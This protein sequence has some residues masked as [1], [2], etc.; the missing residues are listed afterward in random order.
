MKKFLIVSSL[1]AMLCST[2][3]SAELGYGME[4]FMSRDSQKERVFVTFKEP[5]FLSSDNFLK[6][7]KEKA[8]I[9]QKD[10]IQKYSGRQNNINSLWSANA[11]VLDADRE[12]VREISL[13]KDVDRIFVNPEMKFFDENSFESVDNSNGS[14]YALKSMNVLRAWEDFG[15][16]GAD[17]VAGVVDSGLNKELPVFKGKVIDAKNFAGDIDDVT[18][19]SGH[20]THVSG[21]V[22]GGEVSG[23]LYDLVWG[24]WWQKAGTFE[25]NIGVA[26]E[27]EIL[28]SKCAQDDGNITFEDILEGLEW[29]ADPDGNPDTRDGARVINA[30]LGAD[31]SIP[32]LRQPLINIQK[33]GVFLCFAAGN[34]GKVCGS[35]ADFPEIFAVGAVDS[36]DI[37]AGFSSIGP[38]NFDGKEHIKPDVCAPGVKVI[39]YYGDKLAGVDGTSMAAPNTTGVITL[40]YSANPE[41][42]VD[43]VKDILK[44]SALDLGEQGADN[45]YG[46]GRIDAYKALSI[47]TGKN[48]FKADVYQFDSMRNAVLENLRYADG[49][50]SFENMYNNSSTM[51]N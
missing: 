42:T 14:V 9:S 22:T 50:E 2:A 30:S 8:L 43:E 23:D 47:V 3:F 10:F 24:M 35:P 28:F 36:S 1:A 44:R 49:S 34:S 27:S 37:K 29:M 39:S 21:T 17:T 12:L 31:T 6:D 18:D 26:P 15:I 5:S 20:G 51:L 4:D 11:V 16:K 33:T 41:L 32:E 48:Q 25:G 45:L 19:K 7:L 40:L 13:R 38:V 46:H